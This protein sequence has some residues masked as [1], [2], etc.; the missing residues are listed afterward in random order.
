MIGSVERVWRHVSVRPLVPVFMLVLVTR[1]PSPTD[2]S[3]RATGYGG[4]IPVP[5]SAGQGN[6]SPRPDPVPEQKHRDQRSA[7]GRILY[8]TD[9]APATTTAPRSVAKPQ[10]ERRVVE[11]RSSSNSSPNS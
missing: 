2:P 10:C 4:V 1:S 7:R 3:R 11:G 8:A 9:R 6:T 5:V